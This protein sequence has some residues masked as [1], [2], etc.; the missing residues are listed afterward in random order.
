[1]VLHALHFWI[2]DREVILLDRPE[3]IS[4]ESEIEFALQIWLWIV[5]PDPRRFQIAVAALI[6][7]RWT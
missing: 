2:C 1:M 3:V 7:L 6:M 4:K 5:S